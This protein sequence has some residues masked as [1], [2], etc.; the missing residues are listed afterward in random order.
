M[1][2]GQLTNVRIMFINVFILIQLN[3]LQQGKSRAFNL[4]VMLR[5]RYADFLGDIYTPEALTA[6]ST[7][8]DRT[9]MSLLLVLAGLWPPAS[10]QQWNQFISWQPIAI[11]YKPKADDYVW[12]MLF[13]TCL[14][15]VEK[16]M[17]FVL[18]YS[19]TQ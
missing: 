16:I 15:G 2:L 6:S 3:F 14:E 7:D 1:G 9:K 17:L 4:G 18:A 11:N 8:Y 12:K 19:K 13:M 5:R 10:T